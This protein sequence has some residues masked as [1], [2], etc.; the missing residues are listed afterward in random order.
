[1]TLN[2]LRQRT[3]QSSFVQHPFDSDHAGRTM[4]LVAQTPQSLLLNGKLKGFDH[5]F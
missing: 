2:H 4:R 1:V 5:S 3:A